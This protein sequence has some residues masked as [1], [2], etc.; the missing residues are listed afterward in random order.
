MENCSALYF[1]SYLPELNYQANVFAAYFF[2]AYSNITA[3]VFA[4]N[5][6]AAYI[7]GQRICCIF[8]FSSVLLVGLFG[9][10]FT[11]RLFVLYKCCKMGGGLVGNV[12]WVKCCAVI[13]H[14]IS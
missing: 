10:V 14:S 12:I 6:F 5:V 7:T 8:C 1:L 13:G 9:Q 11:W 4:A 2:L 3:N